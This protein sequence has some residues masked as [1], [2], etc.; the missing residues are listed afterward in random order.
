MDCFF[1][2][3]AGRLSENIYTFMAEAAD[4]KARYRCDASNSM[5]KKALSVEIE[6]FVLCKNNL[7][8]FIYNRY[9]AIN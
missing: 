4:N 2:R 1:P 9:L 8:E 5:S 3:T 6:L 7:I